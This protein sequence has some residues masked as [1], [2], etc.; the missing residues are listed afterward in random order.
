MIDNRLAPVCEPPM[1]NFPVDTAWM[2]A[3]EPKP[4]EM[5]RS[6]PRFLK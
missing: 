5:S 6:M 1:S 4:R 3:S 2:A